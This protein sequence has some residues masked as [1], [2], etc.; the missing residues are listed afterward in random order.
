M[1]KYMIAL[2]NYK[3]SNCFEYINFFALRFEP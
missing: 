1:T 2:T 3:A